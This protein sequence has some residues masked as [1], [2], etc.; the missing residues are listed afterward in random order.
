MSNSY[1]PIEDSLGYKSVKDALWK[2]FSEN[3][4]DIEIIRGEYENFGFQFSYKS[5][6]ATMWISATAKNT[7]FEYGEGGHFTISVPNPKYPK[8]S[9]L[10]TIYFHNLLTDTELRDK[11]KDAFGKKKGTIERALSILKQYVDSIREEKNE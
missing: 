8:H 2:V 9:F 10:E 5:Y 4:D 3:L 11:V 6:I 7:Q 1:L